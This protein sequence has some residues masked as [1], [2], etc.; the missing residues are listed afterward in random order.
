MQ[1]T[2]ET[3]TVLVVTTT[4]IILLL[5]LF[6]LLLL[7]LNQKRQIGFQRKLQTLQ[8][9]YERNL[10]NVQL[11]VQ[12]QTLHHVSRE[13][14]DNI[15]LSLTLAKLNL[16]RFQNELHVNSNSD[17]TESVELISKAIHDLSS[18]TRGLNS[19][20]IASNGLIK[21]LEEEC[22]RINKIG[23]IDVILKVTGDA[24]YGDSQKELFLF[25]IAQEALNN[26][27]KYAKASKA[28][29]ILHYE[30]E[31][32]RLEITDNGRGIDF[33]TTPRMGSGLL[34][35]E[36]RAKLLNGSFK[37]ESGNDGTRITV[38]IPIK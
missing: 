35:M 28:I 5:G 32:L 37:I 31:E 22:N 9:E 33:T 19:G 27:I 26:V 4:V 36:S 21:A 13:I 24:V 23:I 20:A 16:N 38:I 3:I 15:G 14:H 17:L 6:V 12:E 29:V 25:R 2:R 8:N 11:E 1:S 10:L 34:N 7:Y 18:I 30:K